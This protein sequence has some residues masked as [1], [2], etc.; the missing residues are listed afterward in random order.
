MITLLWLYE[1][2]SS[3]FYAFFHHHCAIL[4][5][6]REQHKNVFVC[7]IVCV[8]CLIMLFELSQL[9]R[10][11][12]VSLCTQKHPGAVTPMAWSVSLTLS[13]SLHLQFIIIIVVVFFCFFFSFRLYPALQN[14]RVAAK[15]H[16]AKL[17]K[18]QIYL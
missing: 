3:S 12:T 18:D 1:H 7:F 11:H 6:I 5:T 14:A 8:V 13:L 2:T 16:K 15:P 17:Y 9:P 10:A 4:E